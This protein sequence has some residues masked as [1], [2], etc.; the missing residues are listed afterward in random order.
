MKNF[1]GFK[2][3]NADMSNDKSCDNH[4]RRKFKGSVFCFSAQ[5]ESV[6]KCVFEKKPR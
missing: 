6:S 2:S 1:G 4:D 5:S 3:E